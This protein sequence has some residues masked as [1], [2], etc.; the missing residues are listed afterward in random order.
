MSGTGRTASPVPSAP[1]LLRLAAFAFSA[2]ILIA[3][4]YLLTAARIADQQLATQR[5]A[6]AEVLPTNLHD[7][8]LLSARFE[9]DPAGSDY[10]QLSLLGL[11]EPR[12]AYLAMKDGT[13]VGVILPLET[14]Q[15]YGG[16]IVLLI[17]I[18]AEGELT[19]VR[20]VQ[21]NETVGLGDKIDLAISSWMHSFDN[22]SLANTPDVLWYV[23]KDGGDFDQFVGATITPRAV[24]AAV[25]NALLFFDA[26]RERLLPP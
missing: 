2:G 12:A 16:P 6:L 19:G 21:H 22:R 1:L 11:H 7:N 20:T 13:A 5:A 24:V 9:L 23:K 15:G 4:V 3:G 25:H 17:G 8:D 18:T 10:Q 14:E 26:N